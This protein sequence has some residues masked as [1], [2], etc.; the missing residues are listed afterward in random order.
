MII[1]VFFSFFLACVHYKCACEIAL[2]TKVKGDRENDGTMQFVRTLLI[3][4]TLA[5]RRC[6][7]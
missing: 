6:P 1:L 7:L 4:E 2:A 3:R 5:F